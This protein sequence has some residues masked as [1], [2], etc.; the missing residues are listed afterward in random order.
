MNSWRMVAAGW[1]RDVRAR[2]M[3]L[4][5]AAAGCLGLHLKGQSSTCACCAP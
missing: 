1:E 2:V 4:E 5:L 3:L